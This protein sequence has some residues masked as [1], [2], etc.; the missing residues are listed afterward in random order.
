LL[1]YSSLA[2]IVIWNIGEH[3]KT[4]F[5]SINH[6][7]DPRRYP[8]CQLNVYGKLNV[9]NRPGAV[10]RARALGIL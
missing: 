8:A 6:L 9:K 2:W 3:R 5:D 7:T 4:T 1:D 10:A